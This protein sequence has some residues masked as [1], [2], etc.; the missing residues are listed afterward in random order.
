MPKIIPYAELEEAVQMFQAGVDADQIG[1][2]HGIS[3]R[4][5]L[6]RLA[7]R[8]LHYR[9]PRTRAEQLAIEV[10]QGRI[11]LLRGQMLTV[12]QMA[13]QLRLRPRSLR[14]W[15]A[16][17]M[18]G[19]HAQMK[20]EVRTRQAAAR[21]RPEQPQRPEPTEPL[22]LTRARRAKIKRDYAIGYSIA[23]IARH[24]R[25]HRTT[26]WR[27]LSRQGVRMRP[28]GSRSPMWLRFM[29]QWRAEGRAAGKTG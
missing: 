14:E 19:L 13:L 6:Y 2:V 26:I 5:V 21:R 7:K 1:R 29:R 20:G 28:R 22:A 25:H 24:Y 3:A 9:R 16:K 27:L 18:P 12:S 23:A 17:H 8:G 4:T 11:H 15:M 10:R